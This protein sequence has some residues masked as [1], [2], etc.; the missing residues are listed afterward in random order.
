M[1]EFNNEK[2]NLIDTK[3]IGGFKWELYEHAELGDEAEGIA[4]V[5]SPTCGYA[6]WAYTEESLYYTAT[7]Q[8]EFKWHIILH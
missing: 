5:E 4:Y 2:Y 6:K 1:K 8:N 3:M 7:N